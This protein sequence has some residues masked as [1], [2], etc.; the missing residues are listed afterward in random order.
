[1]TEDED[2]QI[3]V[4]NL[5]AM[6]YK[7]PSPHMRKR[8][9][10]ALSVSVPLWFRAPRLRQE[11]MLM[12]MHRALEAADAVG[13]EVALERT[14]IIHDDDGAELTLTGTGYATRCAASIATENWPDARWALEVLNR[15]GHLVP[16]EAD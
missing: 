14:I 6:G 13:P 4:N 1:M 11:E 8:V 3:V 10:A 16:H 7:P 15:Y 5:K 2:S 9:E 12:Q